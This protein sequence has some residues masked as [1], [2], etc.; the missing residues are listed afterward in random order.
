MENRRWQDWVE[1]ILAIWLFF[2]PFF[3]GYSSPSSTAAYNS[4]VLGVLV[5]IFA[6]WALADPRRWE[7]GINAILGLWL[8]ISPFVLKFNST[9]HVAMW[10]CII[11]GILIGIDALFAMSQRSAGVHVTTR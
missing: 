1:L 2:S 3:L 10:N 9:D 8:I 11:L 7:E 4:Y 6:I 5:A